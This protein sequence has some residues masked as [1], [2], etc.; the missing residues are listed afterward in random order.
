MQS[1]YTRRLAP[2]ELEIFDKATEAI[3][4]EYLR[5]ANHAGLTVTT[6][7]RTRNLPSSKDTGRFLLN[8][9]SKSISHFVSRELIG[10]ATKPA[11]KK[12]AEAV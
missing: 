2:D 9:H 11:T 8:Y 7:G 3:Q 4:A 5:Q 12:A 1:G 10:S 6:N